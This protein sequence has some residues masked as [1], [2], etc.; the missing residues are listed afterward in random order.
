VCRCFIKY[1]VINTH[2]GVKLFFHAFSVSALKVWPLDI[3]QEIPVTY[4]TWAAGKPEVIWAL[5]RRENIRAY[6]KCNPCCPVHKPV[7]IL[8]KLLNLPQISVLNDINS[9][10]VQ[11][12]PSWRQYKKRNSHFGLNEYLDFTVWGQFATFIIVS[13]CILIYRIWYIPTN[14]LFIQ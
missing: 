14:P 3:W 12:L 9:H 7:T 13:P 8:T 1:S 11:Y 6:H 10:V 5:L 2:R 4:C